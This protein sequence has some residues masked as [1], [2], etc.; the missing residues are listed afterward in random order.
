MDGDER[1]FGQPHGLPKIERMLPF[2]ASIPQPEQIFDAAIRKLRDD[3]HGRIRRHFAR[4]NAA[5]QDGVR[6]SCFPAH[7]DA[8]GW[9]R[10]LRYR[11]ERWNGGKIDVVAL[12]RAAFHPQDEHFDF[13]IGQAGVVAEI[14]KAFHGAPGRHAPGGDFIADRLGPGA[15]FVVGHQRHRGRS[16]RAMAGRAALV[17]DAGDLRSPG[18]LGCDGLVRLP[19]SGQQQEASR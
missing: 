14:A 13:G 5:G 18:Q 4:R 8:S 9:R 6:E 11:G 10:R 17:D 7:G 3:L 15:R 1:A 12:G 19:K 2:G 16:A